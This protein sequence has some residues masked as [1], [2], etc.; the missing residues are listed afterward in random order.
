MIFGLAQGIDLYKFLH[1]R[2]HPLG[3]KYSA[4][5]D[6]LNCIDTTPCRGWMNTNETIRLAT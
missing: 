5:Y 1:D 3:V 2:L 6:Y 4:I